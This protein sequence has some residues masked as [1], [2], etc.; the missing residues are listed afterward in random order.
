[1]AKQAS[2]VAGD[3]ASRALWLLMTLAL[4]GLALYVLYAVRHVISLMFICGAIAYLLIPL[5]DWL[6]RWRPPFLSP[7]LLAWLRQ[8]DGGA[9]LYRAGGGLDHRFY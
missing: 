6:A 4:I 3:W 9:G 8:P 1:M 7:P 2:N 5:V